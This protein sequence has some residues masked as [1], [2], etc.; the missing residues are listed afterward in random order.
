MKNEQY[1]P[2]K[3]SFLGMNANSA[4][5]LAYWLHLAFIIFMFIPYFSQL[6]FFAPLIIFLSEK[7]SP[8]VKFHSIQCFLFNAVCQVVMW[9]FSI[10]ILKISGIPFL[11]I[12]TRSYDIQNIASKNI[13]NIF[14]ICLLIFVF[15]IAALIYRIVATV[16]ANEYTEFHMPIIGTWASKIANS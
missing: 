1:G 16:K 15:L 2:H 13:G 4:A 3:S 5:M 11:S 10:S 8:F 9:S 6:S 12:L 7:N 14:L